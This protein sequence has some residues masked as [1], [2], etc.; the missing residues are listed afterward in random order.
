MAIQGDVAKYLAGIPVMVAECN[1]AISQ[2]SV[3][4]V[5]AMGEQSFL[6]AIEFFV[7][8]EKFAAS[9]KEGNSQLERYDDFQ[10]LLVVLKQDSKTLAMI[11]SLFELIFPNYVCELDNGCVNLKSPE[12]SK[13]MGQINPMNFSAFQTTL[14]EL[15]LPQG[16]EDSEEDDFNPINEQAAAIAEKLK[17]ARRLRS[18][19]KKKEGGGGKK[20]LFATY[21]STLA[22]GLGMDVN[23]VLGYTP[24]QLYD[25][26]TRYSNKMAFDLYQKI[27][28]TPLMDASK[29]DEPK[30][31]I[32]SIY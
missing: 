2:P 18:A 5:C 9:V 16:M 25:A 20:S 7:E 26:F 17:E 19:A 6:M 27:A 14:R 31:W 12:T 13:I 24:F 21:V 28:T 23:T 29:M 11:N 3:K 15:F 8:A 1:I 32:D 10:I 4:D 22:V 30:N